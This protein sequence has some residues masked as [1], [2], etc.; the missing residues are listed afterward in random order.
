M[1]AGILDMFFPFFETPLTSDGYPG[2]LKFRIRQR[3]WAHET[4]ETRYAA[5]RRGP[6]GTALH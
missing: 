2:Y 4:R 1:S 3:C 5:K 6:A